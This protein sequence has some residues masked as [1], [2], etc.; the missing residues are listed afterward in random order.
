VT[1]AQSEPDLRA[2]NP[3]PECEAQNLLDAATAGKTPL[4]ATDTW[5][6]SIAFGR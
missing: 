3:D 2:S 6:W 1:K 5:A 4:V